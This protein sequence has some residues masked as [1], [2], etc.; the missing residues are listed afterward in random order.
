M[1]VYVGPAGS[2]ILVGRNAKENEAVT[3]AALPTDT[4]L[5]AA[6]VPGAHVLF[7]GGAPS[8]DLRFAADLAALRSAARTERRVSVHACPRVQV[9]KRA[10]APDGAVELHGRPRVLEGRPG[11]A[12]LAR[13]TGIQT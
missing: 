11:R 2:R 13:F 3:A 4:W 7:P 1:A 9:L 10:G 6:A 12:Q 5:H 8:A